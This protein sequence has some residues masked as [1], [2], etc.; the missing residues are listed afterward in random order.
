MTR[1]NWRNISITLIDPGQPARKTAM[2][3]ML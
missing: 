1:F 3:E 2:S